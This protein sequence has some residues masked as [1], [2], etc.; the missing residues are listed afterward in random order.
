MDVTITLPYLNPTYVHQ[1]VR[2]VVSRLLRSNNIRIDNEM[3]EQRLLKHPHFPSLLCISDILHELGI[4]H[5]AYRTDHVTFEKNFIKP[6]LVFL[7]IKNGLF[8]VVEKLV[9]GRVVV[10]TESGERQ[11]YTTKEFTN[12]WDGVVLELELTDSFKEK[13]QKRRREREENPLYLRNAMVV[14]WFCIAAYLLYDVISNRSYIQSVLLLLSLLGAG[15]SWVLVLQHLNKDNILVKQLCER[16]TNS[17]CDSVLNST[18]TQLASWLSMAEAGFVFFLGNI[19]LLL[20]Y[21]FP[22]LF[23]CIMLFSPLLSVYAIYLQAMVLKEWCKLCMLIHG[24]VI[25]S[26][27]LVVWQ[28]T[29][30]NLSFSAGQII[31]FMFPVLA[32][33]GIRPVVNKL[34]KSSVYVREYLKFKSDPELFNTLLAQQPKISIPEELKIFSFGDLKSD[35]ELVIV[36]NPFCSPCSRV[37]QVIDEWMSQELNFRLTIIF[38]HSPEDVDPNKQFVELISGIREESTLLTVLHAWFEGN[39]DMKSWAKR[40][41]LQQNTLR[42]NQVQLTHWLQLAN[43]TATPTFFVNGYKLPERYKLEDLRYLIAEAL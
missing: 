29:F 25:S 12:V 39:K 26:S 14:C 33:L 10:F 37:H 40:H 28:M 4:A 8:G 13:L 34:K 16:K 24:L 23:F 3:L 30:V 36:S 7:A 11:S 1:P 21:D 38:I 41:S 19:V 43:I 20:N 42:Y 9:D 27:L 17:G 32:W 15:V 31:A 6:V 18:K 2:Y 35:K 5:Q 22:A